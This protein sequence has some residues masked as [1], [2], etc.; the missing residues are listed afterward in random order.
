MAESRRT[1]TSIDVAREAGVSQSAVSR[2]FSLS[3][4]VPPATRETIF[5]AATRLG[6]R[7]NQFARRLITSRSNL[8]ALVAGALTNSLHLD[9]IERFAR[10]AQDRGYRVLLFSAVEGQSLDSAISDILSY[11]PAG[12]LAL[13]GTP[14]DAMVAE[15]HGTG[16]PLVLVG[17]DASDTGA[18]WVSCDNEAAA[19]QIAELLIQ[20]GHRRLAF[21]SSREAETSFSHARERGFCEAA[22]RHGLPAPVVVNGGSSYAG[23]YAAAAPLFAHD[24]RFD[25]VFCGGDAMAL[26]LMDAA[27]R[28]YGLAVPEALSIVGF[29]DAPSASWDS[30]ALTTVR[31]PVDV[32]VA[33][34][35]DMLLRRAGVE[36]V[37]AAGR[38]VPGELV[39]R[40]SARLPYRGAC[41]PNPEN[42]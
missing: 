16:I 14:S 20:A 7:H 12:I 28:E 34:A 18:S 40:R 31:Q 10:T 41:A 26:G 17:R 24:H 13:A 9:I 33:E 6:Y 30:Y 15:C 36:A 29:D 22:M 38:L 11:R 1:V 42:S 25:A 37:P 8:L 4:K 32:M 39:L 23:G 21:L 2:A 5:A 19:R 35:L 3:P 27:R